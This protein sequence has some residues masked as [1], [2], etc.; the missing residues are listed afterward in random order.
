MVSK[1]ESKEE[2]FSYPMTTL[3]MSIANTDGSLCSSDKARFRNELIDDLFTLHPNFDALWIIDAGY[4]M[5]QDKPREIYREFYN[6]LL[7]WILQTA[8]KCPNKI[9]IA[10]DDYRKE[11]IKHGERKRRRNGKDEGRRIQVSGVEQKMPVGKMKSAEFLSNGDSKND[12]MQLF[13]TYLRT[14]EAQRMLNNIEIVFSG[15]ETIWSLKEK[16]Y[17]EEGLSNHEEP[18][19]SGYVCV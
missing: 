1:C 17:N 19:K 10:L 6:D 11:S 14:K 7:I 4:A 15:R 5:R 3:P 2:G 18:D 8:T 12:L 13:G 16:I 9:I